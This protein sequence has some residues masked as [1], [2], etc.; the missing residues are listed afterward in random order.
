MPTLPKLRAPFPWFGGKSRA[1]DLIW[2]RFGDPANYVEPFAGSLAVLLARPDVPRIETCNDL[3]CYLANVWRSIAWAPEEVARWADWPVNEAD[4]HARHRWLVDRAKFRATM[5]RDPEY[6]DAKVAGWWIWGVC[7]WIGSGWCD[8]SRTGESNALPSRAMGGDGTRGQG[9]GKGVH[10]KGMRD[11]PVQLPHLPGGAAG[12]DPAANYG[13]GVH[14]R[15]M[16]PTAK[17]PLLGGTKGT[18]VHRRG[19]LPDQLPHLGN[20]GV[21]GHRPPRDLS[22]QLPHLSDGG[23][24]VHPMHPGGPSEQLPSLGGTGMDSGRGMNAAPARSAILDTMQAIAARLRGVRVAC[25]DFERILSDSITWRHGPTAVLLDPEYPEGEQV[26]AEGSVKRGDAE[27]VWFR[28]A[29]WAEEH[30]KDERLRICLCGYAGTWT[31]PAGWTEIPWKAKGGYG[32]QRKD[33]ANENAARERLW[34]SPGC[35]NPTPAQGQLF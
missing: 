13:K 8:P 22:E 25:G 35:L 15:T 9:W 6:F 29:R 18:G 31:P 12:S 28:A 34:F 30:G 17:I 7:A 26:Y 16:R 10:A 11:L 23:T 20:A 21:G 1:V 32:S 33:G 3:D 14:S 2:P 27:H 19:A 24:G 5:R 4:L